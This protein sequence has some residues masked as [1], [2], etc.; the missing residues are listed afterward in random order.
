[1]IDGAPEVA[2]LA[3]D[4]HVDLVEMPSPMGVGPPV[5]SPLA[6]ELAGEHRAEPVP[7]QAHRLVADIDATL[8]QQVLDIAGN[9]RTS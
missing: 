7:P 5:L 2:H 3:I 9:G 1:M 8:E 6:A 4:L